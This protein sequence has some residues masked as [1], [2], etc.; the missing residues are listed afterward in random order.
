ME[1]ERQRQ[2]E[3]LE[4]NGAFYQEMMRVLGGCV[5]RADN[6]ELWLHANYISKILETAFNMRATIERAE[7][8]GAG[9]A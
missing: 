7:E 2:A 8:A 6:E 1:T 5:E 9:N 3:F 4:R